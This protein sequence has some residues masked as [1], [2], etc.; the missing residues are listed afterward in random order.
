MKK[1]GMNKFDSALK[2]IQKLLDKET[3]R[4]KK[5]SS[6]LY[7]YARKGERMYDVGV[8]NGAY[9]QALV[10]EGKVLE[11]INRM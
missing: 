11:I 1:S 7:K 2:K 3:K 10:T 6:A 9:Y 5:K 4:A 8:E